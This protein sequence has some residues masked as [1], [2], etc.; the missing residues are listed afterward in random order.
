MGPGPWTCCPDLEWWTDLSHHP[1][2][3]YLGPGLALW[4]EEQLESYLLV[5]WEEQ[6]QAWEPVVAVVAEAVWEL[7]AAAEVEAEVEL[8]ESAGT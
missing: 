4:M 2:P 3:L 1:R 6:E 8:A 7:A 5:A